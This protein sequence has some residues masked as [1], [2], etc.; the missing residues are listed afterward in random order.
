M[1]A[2]EKD[3]LRE[4]LDNVYE[5]EALIQLALMREDC[6]LDLLRL[7][8]KKKRLI[9]GTDSDTLPS[10]NSFPYENV[11]NQEIEKDSFDLNKKMN[12]TDLIDSKDDVTTKEEKENVIA[13]YSIENEETPLEENVVNISEV[14]NVDNDSVFSSTEENDTKG[15][16]N[17]EPI[18]I[19]TAEPRKLRGRLVFSINDRY[20]FK[21]E[22]FNNSDAEL[23]TTLAFVA[24]MDNYEEAEEYF[25]GDLN[26]DP[27]NQTVADFLE[28]LSKYFN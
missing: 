20:R 8:E 11:A 2:Q 7:I 18:A 22:L 24:S 10:H 21:R 13:E 1:K 14:E 3:K 15:V 25:I 19:P 28:I 17:F 23:N 16:E 27:K 26:L 4:L 5:L 9:S 12:E 6:S